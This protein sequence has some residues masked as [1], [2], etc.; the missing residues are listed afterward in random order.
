MSDN[1]ANLRKTETQV[2]SIFIERWSPRSYL[3]ENISDQ[4]LFSLFEAARWAPSCYNEQP[5]KFL[6]AKNPHDKEIFLSLLVEQNKS[7]AKH[8]PILLFVI[9]K[10]NFDRNKKP[11]D[12]ATF[13]AG[14]AWMSFALQARNK[15]LYTHA[16][17][18][19]NKEKAYDVLKVPKESYEIIAAIALGKK[20]EPSQLA[21]G[22]KEIEN[23]NGRKP[24]KEMYI[25]GSYFDLDLLTDASKS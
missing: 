22:L 4:D 17:A 1:F 15:G 3:E 13:D 2:D 19:F 9:A 16:M 5:W 14:A 8:A 20:G 24:L 25:E 18:G 6:Y 10:K 12:W 7:W 11:N 21:D 23:P